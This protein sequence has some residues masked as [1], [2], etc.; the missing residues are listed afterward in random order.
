MNKG[1][2]EIL[3]RI[4]IF[5]ANHGHS[6][7]IVLRNRN[8]REVYSTMFARNKRARL[9]VDIACSLELCEELAKYNRLELNDLAEA[10][11][12]S[13]DKYNKGKVDV[14]KRADD[15]KRY[16]L[17]IAEYMNKDLLCDTYYLFDLYK[18]E[19]EEIML[20]Y[21]FMCNKM[22]ITDYKF[23]ELLPDCQIVKGN[24]KEQ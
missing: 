22:E 21:N 8:Y 17:K 6:V 3:D 13:I 15:I 9:V 24:G 11:K 14:T 20:T 2:R 5:E 19:P 16:C 23:E 18:Y 4:D 12:M 10:V 1:Y 7:D